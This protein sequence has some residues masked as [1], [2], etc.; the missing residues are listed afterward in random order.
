LSEEELLKIDKTMLATIVAEEDDGSDRYKSLR[1]SQKHI[2]TEKDET[3]SKNSD[4]SNE[5]HENEDHHD[6][7][8]EDEDIFDILRKEVQEE[9]N[10]PESSEP[11][12]TNLDSSTLT[13]YSSNVQYLSDHIDWLSIK[14][15]VLNLT[16]EREENLSRD[17]RQELQLRELKAK[18]QMLRAK[19]EKRLEVIF[20]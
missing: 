19:C 18:E 8:P 15:R 20:F 14:I 6:S 2:D 7:N 1:S 10:N 13:P 5:K 4:E 11:T 9:K 3:Q 16:R 17:P 12:E